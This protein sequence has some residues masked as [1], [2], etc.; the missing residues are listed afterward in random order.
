MVWQMRGTKRLFTRWDAKKRF[1][2]ACE[3]ERTIAGAARRAQIH[4]SRVYRWIADDPTFVQEIEQA[5]ER[6]YQRWIKE[7]YEPQLTPRQAAR[8]RN[9]ITRRALRRHDT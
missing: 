5:F 9:S 6:G 3:H 2:D 1:L 4:R 7:H 8:R